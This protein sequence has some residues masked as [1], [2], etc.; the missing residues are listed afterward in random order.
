MSSHGLLRDINS[1]SPAPLLS[2]LVPFGAGSATDR[3]LTALAVPTAAVT[4]RLAAVALDIAF[5][6]ILGWVLGTRSPMV[7]MRPDDLAFAMIF[8]GLLVLG[9]IY[10]AAAEIAAEYAQFV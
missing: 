4:G 9:R 5:R 1:R 2:L 3:L 8:V 7:L 6:P 10:K